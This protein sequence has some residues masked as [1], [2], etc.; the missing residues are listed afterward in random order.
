[1][2]CHNRIHLNT[3]RISRCLGIKVFNRII[4]FVSFFFLLKFNCFIALRKMS[5]LSGIFL[6]FQEHLNAEQDV[7]EVSI[8]YLLLLFL[9]CFSG[10]VSLHYSSIIIMLLRLCISIEHKKFQKSKFCLHY[11]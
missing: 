4:F 11:S 9:F 3:K 10:F 7:R 8:K 6:N 1:M 5:D 2:K